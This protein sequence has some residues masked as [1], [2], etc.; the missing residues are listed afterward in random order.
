M[1][2][3]LH[4]LCAAPLLAALLLATPLA[5][6]LDPIDVPSVSTPGIHGPDTVVTTPAVPGMDVVIPTVVV[7]GG[8]GV[9]YSH[10]WETVTGGSSCVHLGKTEDWTVLRGGR[11]TRLHGLEAQEIFVHGPDVE[12]RVL[13]PEGAKLGYTGDPGQCA[14]IGVD[15]VEP[16]ECR[17]VVYVLPWDGIPVTFFVGR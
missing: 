8:Q 3:T 15:G 5:A 2:P 12:E 17:F 7:P 1:L 14:T 11:W 6:A 10:C 13:V 9:E 4:A 16:H